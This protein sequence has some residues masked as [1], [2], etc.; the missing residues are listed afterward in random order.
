MKRALA[1]AA[2]LAFGGYYAA[3]VAARAHLEAPAPSLILTDR[4]GAFLAQLGH[5]R[6]L[7]G[8]ALAIDYGF[9]PLDPPPER[10]VRATLALED[11]RFER[12]PGVDPLALARAAWHLL[13]GGPRSGGSTI[14]MQVARM[15]R[16]A[17][18]TPWNKALEAGTALALTARYGRP[19]LLAHYLRLVPYGNGSHGIGHAARYYFDKPAADLGWAEI[20]LLSAIPQAPALHNPR[21]P[22]GLERARARGMKALAILAEQ[23]AIPPGELETARAQLARLTLPPAPRR[24]EALPLI[25]RLARQIAQAGVQGLD[26]ADPRIRTSLDLGLQRRL[27][28]LARQSLA[29][30]RAAGA[31]QAA[32]M[33]MRRESR[34]VLVAIGA[35]APEGEGGGFDWTA[36]PRSPGSTLKPFL[37]ALALQRGQ[38]ET[39][40]ILPDLPDRASGIG[41]ADGGYLGPLLP[42]QALANSRNVP[43]V[44]LLRRI[45]LE[46]GY[47][48]LEDLG[49]HEGERAADEFGLGL[50]I[51]AMPTRLDRLLRAYGA[52]ADD[53]RLREPVWY[54]GQPEAPARRA[55]SP[56]TARLVTD[57]LADPQARLPSFPRHGATEHPFPVA[58]KTGTSQGYRDGWTMAFSADYVIGVWAGRADAGPMRHL[59]G[60]N[61]ARLAQA[62]MLA[63]HDTRA[64]ALTEGHFPPPEGHRRLALCARTGAPAGQGCVPVLE[65]WVPEESGAEGEALAA[66]RLQ[67]AR[68]LAPEA[69]A[70]PALSILSPVHESRLWRNPDLPPALNRIALRAAV[71][72]GVSQVL[73]LVDGEPFALA[74]PDEV[75]HWPMSPG[76]HRFQLRLPFQAEALSR[77]VRI[78]VE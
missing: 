71:G 73:W 13:T 67:P 15:Q 14:A 52:L 22:A 18:R 61:V 16:P 66:P 45:G 6:R 33:V 34:E 10:L 54:H 24:P 39:R 56:T 55:F 48:F 37:Y 7:P 25:A 77:P 27:A 21:R 58:L 35:A 42:R 19:A 63:L 9:W 70:L 65:E 50:A 44:G 40:E 41:N 69:A 11:R 68:F 36:E 51:G 20:A 8:G 17:P 49:L 53:G 47:A 43:V 26:P 57:F 76:A 23:G 32:L 74:A 64:D 30:W 78:T 31:E 1:L 59:G 46:R 29:E 62:V 60:A 72:P 5:E 75:V 28:A 12:H 4:H 3:E 38:L 2:A